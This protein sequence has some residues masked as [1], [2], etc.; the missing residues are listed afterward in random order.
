MWPKISRFGLLQPGRATHAGVMILSQ[1]ITA[2]SSHP[3]RARRARCLTPAAACQGT[4]VLYCTLGTLFRGVMAEIGI[5]ASLRRRRRVVWGSTR[6][7]GYGLPCGSGPG[8]PGR[9]D[10]LRATRLRSHRRIL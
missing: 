2:T 1:M 8:R 5:P 10:R 9:A 6:S 7:S 3:S 4:Q